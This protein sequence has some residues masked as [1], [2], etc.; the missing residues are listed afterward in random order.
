MYGQ[1]LGR[2]GGQELLTFVPPELSLTPSRPRALSVRV[3]WDVVVW[4]SGD[5]EGR[6][7]LVW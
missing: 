7:H 3:V 2:E 4:R 6:G 5:K 1:W